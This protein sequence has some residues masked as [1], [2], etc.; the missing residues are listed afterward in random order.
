MCAFIRSSHRR[1]RIAACTATLVVPLLLPLGSAARAA[2]PPAAAPEADA[3]AEG[4]Q[5]LPLRP[6][7]PST[8]AGGGPAS[9]AL[10]V[11][12]L[13]ITKTEPFSLLG[14]V[15]Q[16]PQARLDGR[17][18]VRT[19][20]RSSG[21]WSRWRE[22][23]A[24]TDHAPEP[25]TAE[26]GDPGL[27]GGTSP[28]WVGSSDAVQV[29]VE[30][31]DDE[32][33][34]ERLP[35]GLRLELIDPL[36]GRPDGAAQD[37]ESV[38]ADAQSTAKTVAR[39][40]ATDDHVGP[41][42]GI[43]IRSGWGADEGL[44]ESGFAYTDRVRT[45]FVH[46]TAGSNSYA[47]KNADEVLRGIYSY[48]VT[49]LGWRDVGYNFFVDRC[50]TIYEGRAG[51]VTEPVMGAHTYGHN[52]NSM[53][54]AVLGSFSDTKPSKR[55]LEGVAKLTAW[56]LGL[57]G[58]NPTRSQERISGGGKYAAGTTVR[59]DNI[60]GHRDG[61]STDCPGDRLYGELSTIRATAA[62]LQGR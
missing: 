32:S 54:I 5:S 40:T 42:P 48:H 34:A 11:Q 23:E 10:G 39:P 59:L 53:G 8:R 37:A 4:I 29:R 52:H 9:P 55:A 3:E 58:V 16:D 19:R 12:G 25:G 35:E 49:S 22:L 20:T 57:F 38:A 26:S 44:R 46:H 18:Q 36:T 51:G 31:A 1:A 56:K 33:S 24:Q 41:R 2:E 27:R 7:T 47:C 60:S 43:V 17:V 13:P 45:A 15:W 61:Y 21:H 50:G 62:R 30:P 14:V 28:L 6:L